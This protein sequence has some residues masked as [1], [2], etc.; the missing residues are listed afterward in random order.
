MLSCGICLENYPK[1]Y[2]W[3]CGQSSFCKQCSITWVVNS[4]NSKTVPNCIS[5]CNNHDVSLEFIRDLCKEDNDTV[6]KADYIYTE[7]SITP[8]RRLYCS[9]CSFPHEKSE[10]QKV[11]NCLHCKSKT[12]MLCAM[13]WKGKTHKCKGIDSQTL[14]SL[15][16]AGFQFCTCGMT[17]ERSDFCNKII[18]RCGR[19]FCYKC[20][21]DYEIGENHSLKKSCACAAYDDDI[22]YI[23]YAER[24]FQI[25]MNGLNNMKKQDIVELMVT[26]AAS[27][28]T[29]MITD[30]KNKMTDN[31]EKGAVA[32]LKGTI[33]SCLIQMVSF[34]FGCQAF[35]GFNIKTLQ[36]IENLIVKARSKQAEMSITRQQLLNTYSE[37]IETKRKL[38]ELENSI[39][40][41]KKQKL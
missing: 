9:N 30:Y 3:E 19:T 7:N 33:F 39:E 41:S 5:G 36:D 37:L 6:H 2:K 8:N 34:E 29:N 23:M 28:F 26:K 17:I 4:I 18:C 11:L 25:I 21:V 14:S 10:K 20:N 38:N 27:T 24:V 13:A 1:L 12:C 22:M 32:R 40:N 31:R 35:D 15:T 16:D